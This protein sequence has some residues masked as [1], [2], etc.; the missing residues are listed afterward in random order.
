MQKPSS[1][2]EHYRKEA[3]KYHELAKSAEPA[4]LGDV[5]RQ[6]AVRYMFMAEDV[7]KWQERHGVDRAGTDSLPETSRS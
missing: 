1:R 2:A 6:V 4:Y 5:Y 7:S 3:A